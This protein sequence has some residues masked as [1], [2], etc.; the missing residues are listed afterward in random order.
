[1]RKDKLNNGNVKRVSQIPIINATAAGIDV[2]DSE[3]MV[4]Y[5]INS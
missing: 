5:P 2:S 4:A 1:M 3:M